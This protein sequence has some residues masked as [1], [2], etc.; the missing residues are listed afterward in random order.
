MAKG[1]QLAQ[2]VDAFMAAPKTLHGTRAPEWSRARDSYAVRLKLPIE[3]AG[4]LSGQHLLIEAFPDRNPILFTIGLLFNER[5]VCRVD[6]DTAATHSNNWAPGLPPFVQGPHWHS[7]ELNRDEL[8]KRPSQYLRL[9]YAIEF[10]Q[11]RA[12]DACLRWYC[13]TRNIT[14]GPHGIDY[15]HK[16]FLL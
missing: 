11:A 13:D 14:L 7:W 5:C 9:P 2:A 1:D 3:L 12:F 15:P 4:E 6:Y 8:R 10:T 16:S